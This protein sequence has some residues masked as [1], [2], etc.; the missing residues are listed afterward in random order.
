[1]M[2]MAHTKI[3]QATSNLH[4]SIVKTCE[5]IAEGVF[6]NTTSFDATDNVFNDNTRTGDDGI[7]KAVSDCQGCA[8]GF[9]F[10]LIDDDAFGP[11]ALE[12]RIL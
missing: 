4:H 2:S 5:M 1:M 8:A 12:T 7:D 3:V 9:L 11:K 10:G 6:E